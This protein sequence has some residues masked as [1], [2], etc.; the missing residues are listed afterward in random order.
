MLDDAAVARGAEELQRVGLEAEPHHASQLVI[1]GQ[2][3]SLPDH[4]IL[5]PHLNRVTS[6]AVNKN[7]AGNH[8][9]GT[10]R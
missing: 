4:A 2:Q 9:H 6:E 3:I 7:E 8:G 5:L 1:V 10:L